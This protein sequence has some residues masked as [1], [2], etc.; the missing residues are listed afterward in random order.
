M[1][2][3]WHPSGRCVKHK[4]SRTRVIGQ[5]GN[6]G[7][8]HTTISHHQRGEV[9]ARS[10]S[11]SLTGSSLKFRWR[12]CADQSQKASRFCFQGDD[13][14]GD[15]LQATCSQSAKTLVVNTCSSGGGGGEGSEGCLLSSCIIIIIY[16]YARA[17]NS[18]I[19]QHFTS[20]EDHFSPN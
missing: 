2:L 10:P 3:T 7:V 15:G 14:S 6:W 18:K 8:L 9:A 1:Q 20:F 11:I 12:S 5:Q 19:Y 13:V 16:Y 4:Q 17:P